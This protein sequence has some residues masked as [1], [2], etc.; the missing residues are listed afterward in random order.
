M[1]KGLGCTNQRGKDGNFIQGMLT[2]SRKTRMRWWVGIAVTGQCSVH[3]GD[4]S[5]GT[6]DYFGVGRGSSGVQ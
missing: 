6:T 4:G 3:F 5:M 1:T 2:E